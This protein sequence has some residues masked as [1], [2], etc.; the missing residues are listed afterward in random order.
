MLQLQLENEESENNNLPNEPETVSLVHENDP[1]HSAGSDRYPAPSTPQLKQGLRLLNDGEC[2]DQMNCSAE[3]ESGEQDGESKSVETTCGDSIAEGILQECKHQIT[4]KSLIKEEEESANGFK[5]ER[6][7][8]LDQ[9]NKDSLSNKDRGSAEN[10][11]K[12]S[13]L[14]NASGPRANRKKIKVTECTEVM[15]NLP[16]I[17]DVKSI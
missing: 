1:E 5:S 7:M 15:T 16:I 14:N 12:S 6:K 10:P 9:H 13:G 2:Q 3:K 8:S 4:R 11:C 17:P